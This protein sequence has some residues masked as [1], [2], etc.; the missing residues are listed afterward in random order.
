MVFVMVLV[1][2]WVAPDVFWGETLHAS[3]R[4]IVT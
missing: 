2:E 4:G 1:H 3:N